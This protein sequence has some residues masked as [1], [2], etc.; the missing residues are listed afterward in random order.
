MKIK[1]FLS[2]VQS[3]SSHFQTEAS[4]K[5]RSRRFSVVWGSEGTRASSTKTHPSDF[6]PR[7]TLNRSTLR[8]DVAPGRSNASMQEPSATT[9][10]WP[11]VRPVMLA[12]LSLSNSTSY[13]RSTDQ[14]QF[15]SNGNP[16]AFVPCES[17]MTAMTI[18]PIA[19]LIFT[20]SLCRY[21]IY[22]IAASAAALPA[23]VPVATA[24]PVTR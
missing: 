13:G 15:H 12:I 6:V 23:A 21:Y 20:F 4:A 9:R 18:K 3:A 24:E 22:A 10:K 14:V 11:G 2:A 8:D 16:A 7:G 19:V 1:P 5:E 17:N